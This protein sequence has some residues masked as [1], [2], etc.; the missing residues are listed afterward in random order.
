L[1]RSE[2]AEDDHDEAGKLPHGENYI[3]ERCESSQRG[4][5]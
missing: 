3:A 5:D 2:S 4:C 1:R